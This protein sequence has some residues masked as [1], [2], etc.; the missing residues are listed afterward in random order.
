MMNVLGIVASGATE[1]HRFRFAAK[2]T[3]MGKAKGM[4]YEGMVYEGKKAH[5]RLGGLRT[6]VLAQSSLFALLESE[7]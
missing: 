3:G 7:G 6:R 2:A 4:V 1:D 5:V